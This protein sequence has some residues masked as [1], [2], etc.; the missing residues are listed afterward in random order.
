MQWR[1]SRGA[2]R[3]RMSLMTTQRPRKGVAAI[4]LVRRACTMAAYSHSISG[5]T[6]TRH[7]RRPITLPKLRCLQQK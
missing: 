1:R 6:K 4:T 3:N 7:A 5:R 2:V